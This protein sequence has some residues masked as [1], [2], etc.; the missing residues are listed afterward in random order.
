MWICEIWDNFMKI[1]YFVNNCL[2]TVWI[3]KSCYTYVTHLIVIFCR[4]TT[5]RFYII[6][7]QLN[8]DLPFQF[9]V[10]YILPAWPVDLP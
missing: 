10:F 6:D 1:W 7:F 8:A 3:L 4:T 5:F 9:S 2:I